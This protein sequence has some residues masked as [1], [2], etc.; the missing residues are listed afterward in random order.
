MS[1]PH[2]SFDRRV[3][4]LERR[5]DAIAIAMADMARTCSN[6]E[7][8]EYIRCLFH[9]SYSDPG[10]LDRII[11]IYL[12]FTHIRAKADMQESIADFFFLVERCVYALFG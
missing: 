7:Y 2:A 1:G 10:I 8:D 4:I 11:K 5:R 9:F 6:E 12:Q 3:S